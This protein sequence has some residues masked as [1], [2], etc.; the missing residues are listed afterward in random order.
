MRL[1]KAKS[2]ACHYPFCRL[3]AMRQVKCGTRGQRRTNMQL[4][5]ASEIPDRQHTEISPLPSAATRQRQHASMFYVSAA[6]AYRLAAAEQTTVPR[7]SMPRKSVRSATVA[8]DHHGRDTKT[9]CTLLIGQGTVSFR[10]PTCL[11]N[12]DVPPNHCCASICCDTLDTPC[13]QSCR[14]SVLSC[15]S[16]LRRW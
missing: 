9:C 3:V 12:V 6:A 1:R 8:H 7:R 14:L 10:S 15:C 4:I 2:L 13:S 16:S 11:Y 5:P